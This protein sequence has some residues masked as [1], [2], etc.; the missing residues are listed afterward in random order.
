MS[1]SYIK[2]IYSDESY[3][4][5]NIDH[6][7]VTCILFIIVFYVVG[8]T[9]IRSNVE[10]LRDNWGEKR[11]DLLVLPFAGS[12]N[13]AEGESSMDYTKNN[14]KL[15]MDVVITK[16][17]SLQ[18]DVYTVPLKLILGTLKAIISNVNIVKQFMGKIAGNIGKGFY[19]IRRKVLNVIEELQFML[20]KSL[21]SI[22]KVLGVVTT[23]M[24]VAMAG[25]LSIRGFF[26]AFLKFIKFIIMLIAGLIVA[27]FASAFLLMFVP[28][29]WVPA[30][31]IF[32]LTIAIIGLLVII[33]SLFTLIYPIISSIL[34]RK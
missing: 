8:L 32:L 9:Y 30:A 31:A 28:F 22:A 14:F 29:G 12:I 11:C 1:E 33:V 3:I 26:G 2:Y 21:D 27:T 15:C 19:I 7:L 4:S 6:V 18:V 34:D 13:A 16:I 25:V 24:Y 20:I 17:V 10:Y 5:R 23:S